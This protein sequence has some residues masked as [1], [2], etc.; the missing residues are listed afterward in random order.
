VWR[1]FYDRH[2]GT[3]KLDIPDR[4]DDAPEWVAVVKR[5]VPADSLAAWQ[6]DRAVKKRALT[7]EITKGIQGLAA[8]AK[9]SHEMTLR[10]EVSAMA[11][12]ASI[13]KEHV[14]LL[15]QAAKGVV[16]DFMRQWQKKMVERLA[17][18]SERQRSQVYGRRMGVGINLEGEGDARQIPAWKT[19][20][21]E[22]LSAEEQQRW[23]DVLAER[24]QLA[25][26]SFSHVALME[27][28]KRVYL[29]AAQRQKLEPVAE[30]VIKKMFGDQGIR[31][32]QEYDLDSTEMIRSL[33]K[34][35]EQDVKPLM[36]DG[37]WKRW[38]DLANYDGSDQRRYIPTNGTK[39]PPPKPPPAKKDGKRLEPPTAESI[40]S[41]H[42]S[43]Q[44]HTLWTKQ[45]A[46][47]QL[48]VEEAARVGALPP[49]GVARLATAAKGAVEN[50]LAPWKSSMD[51][52]VRSQ[53]RDA[54][55]QNVRPKL[56]GMGT[57]SMSGYGSGAED[58]PLWKEA[59]NEVMP[60]D[61]RKLWQQEQDA[62]TD[63]QNA[64]MTGVVLYHLQ[65]QCPITVDQRKSLEPLIKRVVNDYTPDLNGWFSSPWYL[66]SYYVFVPMAGVPEKELE[67]VLG[68]SRM[69]QVKNTVLPRGQEYWDNIKEQ[70]DQR[71]RNGGNSYNGIYITF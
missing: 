69:K 46:A 14:K 47:M 25:L 71:V 12:G 18:M 26:Q 29:T 40:I 44:S 22:I 64:A 38:K 65:R 57:I 31:E 4:A 45:V 70:H 59:L 6:K 10:N 17:T 50:L 41:E 60:P 51:G 2:R 1:D 49:E 32:E 9:D 28:D 3:L 11:E 7:D 68:P 56:D 67:K 21:K 23:E 15:E 20:V 52:Y 43:Q 24:R 16:E 27:M 33:A 30:A 5:L 37:Q 35:R 48:R 55:P 42:L 63:Y 36:D 62:R 58:S 53:L 19:K 66:Y 34:A 13:S 61:K 39:T 54:T 8:Q